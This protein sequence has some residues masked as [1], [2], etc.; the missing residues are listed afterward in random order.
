MQGQLPGVPRKPDPTVALA[1]AEKIGVPPERF[2]YVGDSG[3]DMDCA[4][5]A[6]MRAVGVLWGFRPQEE[7]L[8]NGAE[9][10]IRHP[11][12]LPDIPERMRND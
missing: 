2:V 8:E 3:V 7:L 6:G 10:L 9:W 12:E 4:S 11:G 1:I 5:R